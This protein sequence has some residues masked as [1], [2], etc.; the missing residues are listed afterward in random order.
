MTKVATGEGEFA[1]EVFL[2]TLVKLQGL[3]ELADHVE[4]VQVLEIKAAQAKAEDEALR[5]QVR[6]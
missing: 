4:N 1:D 6:G 3:F 5:A 2:N